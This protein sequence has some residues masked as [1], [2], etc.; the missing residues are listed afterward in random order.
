M[1]EIA[2]MAT[3]AEQP[4]AAAPRP[5]RIQAALRAE[6]LCRGLRLSQAEFARRYGP[7]GAIVRNWAPM[8]SAVSAKD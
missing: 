3:S 1:R 8:R 6:M 7:A 2:E 5:S 4:Q